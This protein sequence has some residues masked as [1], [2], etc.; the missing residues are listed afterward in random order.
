M[1]L[2]KYSGSCAGRQSVELMEDRHYSP[3]SWNRFGPENT[4]RW[5]MP[6][7][8]WPVYRYG[9]GIFKPQMRFPERIFCGLNAEKSFSH[10]T[11]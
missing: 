3:W 9:K 11:L 2:P 6:L 8:D 10:I 5:I 1:W 4:D 7:T